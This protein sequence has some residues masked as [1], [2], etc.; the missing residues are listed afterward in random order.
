MNSLAWLLATHK[1]DKFRN[2]EEAI[3]LAERAC[4]LTSYEN[5]GLVDTLAAAYAA[6]GRFPDAVKT[7]ERA[8][9]LAESANQQQLADEIKKRLEL[10]K[11]GQPYCD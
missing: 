3:R 9:D 10:Y 1:E 5:A 8:I 2:P 6:A 7:T 11:T 4:E